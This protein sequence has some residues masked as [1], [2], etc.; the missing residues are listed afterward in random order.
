VTKPHSS[1]STETAS[2]DTGSQPSVTKLEGTKDRAP[3][4][5]VP[6]DMDRRAAEKVLSLGGW[7]KIRVNG[8][9]QEI[10]PGKT[11]PTEAF[12]L[13]QVELAEK[14]DLTDAGL[15]PLERLS[16][17]IGI[18]LSQDPKVTD[19]GVAHLRNLP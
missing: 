1:P 14:P 18:N 8:E 19:A 16:D 2:R 10:Q 13:T 7:V 5:S 6:G 9:E 3:R 4:D 11:L 12:R 15:E 17:L